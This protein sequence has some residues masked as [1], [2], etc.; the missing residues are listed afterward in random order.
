MHFSASTF[1]TDCETSQFSWSPE[2]RANFAYVLDRWSTCYIE[3]PQSSSGSIC[4]D[5]SFGQVKRGRDIL[6][7]FSLEAMVP[8]NKGKLFETTRWNHLSGAI[9][10]MYHSP[11]S[12]LS[13][14]YILSYQDIIATKS[15]VAAGG[16]N[17]FCCAFCVD[18]VAPCLA[19]KFS[20][21]EV[22][23]EALP[24][25]A[26]RSKYRANDFAFSSVETWWMPAIDCD[27]DWL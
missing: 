7:A 20:R 3:I 2:I 16:L 19:T 26:S 14:N 5:R 11:I 6:N 25:R 27:V 1:P 22:R 18:K 17:V 21:T 15:R 24:R 4:V 12:N 23:F 9:A 13:L 10:I 8:V